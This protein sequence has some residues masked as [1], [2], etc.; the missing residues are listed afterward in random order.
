MCALWPSSSHNLNM[1]I[2]RSLFV[3]LAFVGLVSC[4]SDSS[5]GDQ[6]MTTVR[7]SEV[8]VTTLPI[9]TTS[10][11]PAPST[12]APKRQVTTT[13]PTAPKTKTPTVTGTPSE[14]L[15]KLRA[16]VLAMERQIM[17]SGDFGSYSSRVEALSVKYAGSATLARNRSMSGSSYTAKSGDLTQVWYVEIIDA[18]LVLVER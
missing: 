16:D 2:K 9:T 12:T 11:P 8:P 1:N 10:V 17:S 6:S 4:A 3:S 14:I 18:E 15:D 7:V 13:V 5:S